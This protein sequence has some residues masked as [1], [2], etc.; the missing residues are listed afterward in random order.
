MSCYY[1]VAGLAAICLCY[2]L[3]PEYSYILQMIQQ[4]HCLKFL[5]VHPVL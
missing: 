3:T 1:S 2:V 4:I 5:T